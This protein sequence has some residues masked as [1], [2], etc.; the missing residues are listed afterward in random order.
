MVHIFLYLWKADIK[1]D[2]LETVP[3]VFVISV[4]ITFVQII[5]NHVS[6]SHVFNME[7]T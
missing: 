2:D 7:F 1:L 5:V 4:L 3:S 6:K